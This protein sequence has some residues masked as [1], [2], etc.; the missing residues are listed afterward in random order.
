MLLTFVRSVHVRVLGLFQEAGR[1]SYYSGFGE[2]LMICGED[3]VSGPMWELDQFQTGLGR[4]GSL[5]IA[6]VNWLNRILVSFAGL[7]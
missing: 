5:Y 4:G 2:G 1:E 6:E 3:A 7:I